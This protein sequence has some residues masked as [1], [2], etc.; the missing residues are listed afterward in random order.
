MREQ[1]FVASHP[2][3]EVSRSGC[4][5][6]GEPPLPNSVVA[7]DEALAALGTSRQNASR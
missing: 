5:E 2:E 1:A 7:T 4:A 3:G 6:E